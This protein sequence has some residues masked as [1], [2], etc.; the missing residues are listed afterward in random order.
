MRE[1]KFRG[2]K[3]GSEDWVCGNLIKGLN[4]VCFILCI[5]EKPIRNSGSDW[6]IESPCFKVK[7]ETIGQFTGLKD[8]NGVEIY[9]G[10]ILN[11]GMKTNIDVVFDNGCFNVFKEP[12]G[13]DFDVDENPVRCD[14]RYCEVIGNIHQNPELLK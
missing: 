14:L 8:K 10:D 4:G 2:Q 13:W 11:F 3:E 7:P 1:F 9:E 6:R 12:L 5:N